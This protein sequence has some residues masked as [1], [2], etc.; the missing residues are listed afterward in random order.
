MSDR[1]QRLAIR[2]S[3]FAGG[4]ATLPWLFAAVGWTAHW[5][6]Y[7]NLS[8]T[9]CGGVL[10]WVLIACTMDRYQKARG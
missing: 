6:A 3:A 10:W 7:I 8:N 4:L 2:R 1:E 9:L 5:N